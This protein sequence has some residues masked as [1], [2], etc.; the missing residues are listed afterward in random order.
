MFSL[1]RLKVIVLLL[2]SAVT[3]S[4]AQDKGKIAGKIIDAASTEELIGVS[5]GI[6]GTN[7][8]AASDLDGKFLITLDP[9]TYTVVMSYMGYQTK[10]F[11]NVEVKAGEVTYIE[12]ALAETATEVEEVVIV[13]ERSKETTNTLL[14]EQKNSVS[15]SSGVSAELIRKTPD[16]NTADV[17]K[18]VSGASVQDNR[19]AIIRGLNDRYNMVFLNNAPMS[20]TES[21][22]KAFS[23]DFIPAPLIDNMKI[24]KTATPDMPG[25]FAGGFIQINTRDIPD[26]NTAFV[27][28]QGGM[29][30]ITT[31]NQF[32][33]SALTSKTDWLGFDNGARQL[34]K[35]LIPPEVAIQDFNND[36]KYYTENALKFNN[37]NGYTT[38]SSARPNY[39]V[40]AGISRRFRIG[41]NPLGVILAVTYNN[42]LKT[43]PS[44]LSQIDINPQNPSSSPQTYSG[45]YDVNNYRT[46]ILAGSIL[47]LSYKIGQHSKFTLKNL[48]TST[49]DNQ[50]IFRS[51]S[52]KQD[53]DS[54]SIRLVRD[55]TYWYQSSRLF[56]SQFNGEHVIGSM[57]SKLKYTFS[58]TDINRQNPNLSK[59]TYTSSLTDVRDDDGNHIKY[60]ADQPYTAQI[61]S[62]N[63][64][65]D[66]QKNGKFF[67]TLNERNY[68]AGADYSFPITLPTT[69]M[70]KIE[71]KAGAS[72]FIRN[73]TFNAQTFAYAD[74]PQ[75][76]WNIIN[77]GAPFGSSPRDNWLQQDLTHIYDSPAF[78]YNSQTSYGMFI[79]ENTKSF[80]HYSADAHLTSVF[81]MADIFLLPQLR[82][83][84][85]MRRESYNQNIKAAF[86]NGEDATLS[87][88]VNDWL[89]SGNLIFSITE[90]S[91]LRASASKTVSRPEF[92]EIAPF[93]FYDVNL[94]ATVVGEPSLKRAS[95]QNYDLKY[96]IYP[97]VGQFFAINPFYKHFDSP[98]ENNTESA[99]GQLQYS[100]LNAKAATN[101]GVEL[102]ARTSLQM[103]DSLIG[104]RNLNRFMIYGNYSWIHSKVDLSNQNSTAITSRPLQG[105]SPYV[106]NVGASYSHE[107]LGLDFT[108]NVNRIGRRLAYV[109]TEKVNL[110]WENPRTVLDFSISKRINKYLQ[111]RYT[112]GDLLSQRLVFYNDINDDGKYTSGQDN[113]VY[114]Y[115]NGVVHNLQLNMNF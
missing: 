108:V 4:Q 92:R 61:S 42:Q 39:A 62:K 84:G 77:P 29:N 36:T 88:T 32:S 6:E 28:V 82:L 13:G 54:S 14:L 67:S 87:S 109:A 65:Y 21:D 9:G 94:N 107:K 44:T 25:D 71:L 7:L 45:K 112:I 40:Q 34:P 111:L 106:L 15:V 90:K 18:R 59:T 58:F 37:T 38:T 95:I 47:N 2:L 12:A 69:F 97:W 33:K 43:T 115:R 103:L 56:S 30:S 50:T 99:G 75:T 1:K 68:F 10:K 60:V 41:S 101:Y 24:Q 46:N 86:V 52:S 51:G 8:G 55:Y 89:P 91:N 102:E 57:K 74:G 79:Q 96:E 113:A 17:L 105:Q 53:V 110:I 83:I 72:E 26:Q 81:A 5:V 70:H 100:Y 104:T 98:V 114:N 76:K 3:F 35:D 11:P 27:T 49:S 16:R 23:L 20:S 85:G 93:A 63:E 78:F 19:F 66:S 73:R 22:R 64:G 48:L 31:F 80:N